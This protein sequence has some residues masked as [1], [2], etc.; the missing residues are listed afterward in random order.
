MTELDAVRGNDEE[1]VGEGTDPDIAGPEPLASGHDRPSRVPRSLGTVIVAVAG[2][3]VFIGAT[4]FVWLSWLLSGARAPWSG[5]GLSWLRQVPPS[6]WMVAAVVA[7]ALV[8]AVAT[9]VLTAV[10]VRRQSVAEQAFDFNV[11]AH[12]TAVDQLQAT[13]RAQRMSV[14]QVRVLEEQ[15]D[16]DRDRLDIQ[17]KQFAMERGLQQ[18][19]RESVLRQRFSEAANLLAQPQVA[20][21]L[22]GAY[23]LASVADDWHQFGDDAERQA[24][25]SLL[26]DQLRIVPAAE[27][28][29]ELHRSVVALIRRHRPLS[30]IEGQDGP[31]GGGSASPGLWGSCALDLSNAYIPGVNLIDTDLSGVVLYRAN[32]V[33]AALTNSRLRS[34]VAA[35]VDL[36]QA[37]LGGVD[38]SD[39]DLRSAQ[40]T[41]CWATGADFSRA[42]L[43]GATLAASDLKKA[44]L[45]GT[46]V[47]GC[48]F[49]GADLAEA[50]SIESVDHDGS[51]VWPA[52]M[53]G[54]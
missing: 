45:L 13:V 46:K 33:G 49:S 54:A 40:M 14:R 19:Q 26:C 3:V 50:S 38:F 35:G 17:R 2:I 6:G 11:A 37:N 36:S 39:A 1:A 12:E 9:A 29:F 43:T 42:D 20:V 31:S 22:A 32:M 24:C 23:A 52:G 25:V 41:R 7:A 47:R 21:R 28:D 5:G 18:S 53:R 34:V 51:T 8:V 48:D 30:G 10:A 4:V 44:V 16:T 27:V 15:A